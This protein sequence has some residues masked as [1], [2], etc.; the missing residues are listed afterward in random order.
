MRVP[1]WVNTECDLIK[2]L[3]KGI[4]EFSLNI[5]FVSTKQQNTCRILS[6]FKLLHSE[7]YLDP[8]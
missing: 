8:L 7:L 3:K 1:K 5:P 2:I 4:L 6:A